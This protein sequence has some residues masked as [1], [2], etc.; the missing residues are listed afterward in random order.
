MSSIGAGAQ[1]ISISTSTL[2]STILYR[3]ARSNRPIAIHS[4]DRQDGGPRFW[5]NRLHQIRFSSVH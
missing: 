5:R 2:I 1:S 3:P 4:F